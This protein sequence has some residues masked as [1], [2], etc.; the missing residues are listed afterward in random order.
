MP[1]KRFDQPPEGP[2]MRRIALSQVVE[3]KDGEIARVEDYLAGEEPLEIR[4]GRSSLGVT[5][6]TPGDDIDLAAG[7]L[8]TEG[9]ISCREDLLGMQPSDIA[10][11]NGRTG[12]NLVRV[13]VARKTARPGRRRFSA[14][15]ACGVCGKASI[16]EIRQK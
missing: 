11:G 12:G 5:L 15:S 9:I 2:D 8:L 14:G 4:S 7:F 16:D 3:W 1:R 10:D 13:R 6:R